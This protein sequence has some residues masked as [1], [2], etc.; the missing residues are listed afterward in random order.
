[1]NKDINILNN[2]IQLKKIGLKIVSQIGKGGFSTV[3]HGT[4]D[5]YPDRIFAAKL[6]QYKSTYNSIDIFS[7]QIKR[8]FHYQK[9]CS[10]KY[11]TYANGLFELNID[12]ELCFVLVSEMEKNGDLSLFKNK[13][14]KIK[15]FNENLTTY[16]GGQVLRGL[17][18]LHSMKICHFDIKAN[19][20]FINLKNNC[21]ISDFSLCKDYS[22]L[23][24]YKLCGSGT[25]MYISPESMRNE[26]I[27]VEELQKQ[28]LWSFGI[29]LYRMLY[30][31]FPFE[32]KGDENEVELLKKITYNNLIFSQNNNLSHTIT[33]FISK[34]LEKNYKKRINIEEA[35]KHEF[36]QNFERYIECKEKYYD[37]DRFIHNLINNML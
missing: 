6:I 32:I 1:M 18:H 8:E 22:N 4:I 31:Y 7:N 2:A 11:V 23:Q 37:D 28:D 16:I 3:Y 12:N 14:L 10:G 30:N 13:N 5:K 19:N 21:K 26:E 27:N 25:K 15:T 24:T 34:L 9:L 29:M 36:M 17:N 20:I 35:M 33:D